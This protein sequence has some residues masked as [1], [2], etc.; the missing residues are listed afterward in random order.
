MRKDAYRFGSSVREEWQLFPH[1]LLGYTFLG[2]A[3]R[4]CRQGEIV[5]RIEVGC[6]CRESKMYE[7]Q[8]IQ[9]ADSLVGNMNLLSF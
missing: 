8:H 2:N 5:A 6:K 1:R 3:K 7:I 4:C 9:G